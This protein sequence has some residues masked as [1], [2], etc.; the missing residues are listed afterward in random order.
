[1][2]GTAGTKLKVSEAPVKV[3][4]PL[5]PGLIG[6]GGLAGLAGWLALWY[7]LGGGA[8]QP[9]CLATAAFALSVFALGELLAQV[10]HQPGAANTLRTSGW[11]AALLVVIAAMSLGTFLPAVLSDLASPVLARFGG[12]VGL[13]LLTLLFIGLAVQ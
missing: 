2:A 7:S 6:L 11:L 9:F 13:I 5:G 12:V 1:M 8:A 10:Y 3:N 4:H